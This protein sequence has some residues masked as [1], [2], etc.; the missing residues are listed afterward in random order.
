MR[1]WSAFVATCVIACGGLTYVDYSDP[2]ADLTSAQDGGGANA[3]SLR[4]AGSACAGFDASIFEQGP[5]CAQSSDCLSWHD[6]YAPGLDAAFVEYAECVENHCSAS[7]EYVGTLP[8]TI[9]CTSD[10]YCRAFAQQFVTH[11]EAMG[12]CLPRKTEEGDVLSEQ[13]CSFN[14]SA[15]YH[16]GGDSKHPFC[17]EI[18][19]AFRYA[20]PCA[21]ESTDIAAP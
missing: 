19:G 7:L 8:S 6:A 2:D 13:F 20:A 5:S 11:G 16:G 14:C 18:D 9:R 1:S 10:A 4:H 3:P 21:D 12:K 15:N 17:V